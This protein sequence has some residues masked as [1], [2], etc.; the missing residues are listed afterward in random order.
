M[1]GPNLASVREAL[2]P[3]GRRA[4]AR[5]ALCGA[6]QVR[7][8]VAANPTLPTRGQRLLVDDARSEVRASLA[9][10]PGV[11]PSLLAALAADEDSEVRRHV[12][13]NGRLRAD[14][15][16]LLAAD[17]SPTV[18]RTLLN[19]PGADSDSLE[20]LCR[21]DPYL[22]LGATRIG[23]IPIRLLEILATDDNYEVRQAVAI[24]DQTPEDLLYRLMA[25]RDERVRTTAHHRRFLAQR[26]PRRPMHDAYHRPDA[27]AWPAPPLRAPQRP[28][29]QGDDQGCTSRYRA[30]DDS[31]FRFEFRPLGNR[32]GWRVNVLEMPSYRG[33][34]RGEY[35]T[36]L[37]NQAG[38][39]YICWST[40]ILGLEQAAEVA[41]MWAEATVVY[42]A[43]GRFSV[44]RDRP[45]VS[46][47]PDTPLAARIERHGAP[48]APADV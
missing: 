40:P 16:M 41:A 34:D 33:R 48:A 5:A 36:H 46:I 43:T 31:N 3:A 25:D 6:Y 22:R 2:S 24:H 39:P 9:S 13:A 29:P 18:R 27:P 20:I 4:L 15:S 8:A 23:R 37:Y 30:S 10:N 7:Q 35:A 12:A 45:E 19:N 38:T 47:S 44:P 32:P 28:A 21:D 14:T 11:L 26:Q 17:P 42:I 1:H